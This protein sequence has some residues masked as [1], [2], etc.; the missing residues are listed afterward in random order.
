MDDRKIE[1]FNII[2]KQWAKAK[3]V[4]A[5]VGCSE[6]KAYQIINEVIHE[7][8][9]EGYKPFMRATVPMER[10]LNFLNIDKQ[11]VFE[12]AM[13]EKQLFGLNENEELAS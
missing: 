7:S 1:N 4:M 10:L 3:D 12:A 2:N 8:L 6:S 11:S 5:L 9:K 13:M